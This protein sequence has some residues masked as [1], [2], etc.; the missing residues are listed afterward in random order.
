[1]SA[2]LSDWRDLAEGGL[3]SGIQTRMTGP[4]TKT[5]GGDKCKKGLDS[6]HINNNKALDKCQTPC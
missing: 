3:L 2:N 4:P 1:M 5:F 6:L